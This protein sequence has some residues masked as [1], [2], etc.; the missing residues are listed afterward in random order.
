MRKQIQYPTDD[1]NSLSY[2]PIFKKISKWDAG[3]MYMCR[4][5]QKSAHKDLNT[6]LN[7]E[8]QTD[9]LHSCSRIKLYHMTLSILEMYALAYAAPEIKRYNYAQL[10]C[11]L[12]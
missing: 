5:I 10:S 4:M 1:I 6:N 12:T 9:L 8:N 2:L 3:F 11:L 7:Y